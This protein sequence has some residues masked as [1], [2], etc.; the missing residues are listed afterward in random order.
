M[1]EH[2]QFEE[3][4][5]GSLLY[6]HFERGKEPP[7]MVKF[8][9]KTGIVK[10]PRQANIILLSFVLLGLL[11][12]GHVMFSLF[13]TTE[14]GSTVYREDLT[15]EQRERMPEEFLEAFPSRR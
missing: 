15:A 5:S 2:V 10:T 14:D 4:N 12:T 11:M 7:G 1:T 3:E 9:L 6:G 8:I 13:R